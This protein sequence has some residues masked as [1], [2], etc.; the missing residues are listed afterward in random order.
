MDYSCLLG[1]PLRGRCRSEACQKGCHFLFCV[2]MHKATKSQWSTG[3]N[4]QLVAIKGELT[5]VLK[6]PQL[7]WHTA[8]R[9]RQHPNL[10]TTG[11]GVSLG[12][13]GGCSR[14]LQLIV[15]E[16]E[17]LELSELAQLRRQWTCRSVGLAERQFIRPRTR[18]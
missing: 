2:I 17:G 16:T 8:C 3:W 4:V 7:T 13:R 1:V 14:T 11:G 5:Q 18:R 12:M 15:P 10:D 9:N 6:L